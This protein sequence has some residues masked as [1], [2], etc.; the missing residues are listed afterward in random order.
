MIPE[1]I[2][3]VSRGITVNDYMNGRLSQNLI[4]AACITDC[5]LI[6]L[7]VVCVRWILKPTLHFEN[8]VWIPCC[9]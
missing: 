3:F 5:E 7:S 6:D 2:I 4:C 9:V 8:Y 1:R